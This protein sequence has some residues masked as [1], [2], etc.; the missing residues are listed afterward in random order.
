MDGAGYTWV[1]REIKGDAAGMGGERVKR[2][3]LQLV[4]FDIRVY[5]LALRNWKGYIG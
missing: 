2:Q 4:K 5:L 3:L 1:H